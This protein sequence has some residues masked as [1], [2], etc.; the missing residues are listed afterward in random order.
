MCFCHEMMD[1][2]VTLFA[3]SLRVVSGDSARVSS[4]IHAFD[5]ETVMRF[6]L[7]KAI[8]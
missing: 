8:I 7:A 4:L 1:T 5:E 6:F 3:A 2:Y